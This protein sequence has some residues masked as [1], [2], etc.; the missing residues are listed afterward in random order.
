MGFGW[1]QMGAVAAGIL[2]L[3]GLF[4]ACS[5][6]VDSVQAAG[7]KHV[8]LVTI[9]GLRGDALGAFESWYTRPVSVQ[10]PGDENAKPEA[11]VRV[12]VTPNLDRLAEAS[13][14]YGYALATSSWCAPSVASIMASQ[15]PSYLGFTS[16]ER[17]FEG[18]HVTLAEVL[19]GAGWKTQAFV[20]HPFLRTRYN[21]DQGF[22]EYAV[23]EGETSGER[24][25]KTM[26]QALDAIG[27]LGEHSTLLWVQLGGLGPPFDVEEGGQPLTRAE[28]LR[29]R[30]QWQNEDLSIL[31][32]RYNAGVQRVD[33]QV[34]QLLQA[35][36]EAG[37]D[38]DTVVVCVASNGCELLER[39]HIG[40]GT[41]LADSLVRV[42]CMISVAGVKPGVIE[43]PVSLID[44]APSVLRLVGLRAPRTWQGVSV[45][46]REPV[47]DR[48]LFSE[49]SRARELRAALHSDHKLILDPERGTHQLYDVF[50][51][52]Y[53][54]RDLAI[55]QGALGYDLLEALKAF[56]K[57]IQVE[58]TEH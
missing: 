9:E 3:A 30:D 51:D 28:W 29:Y 4:A 6:S 21:L 19:R 56:E 54:E 48:F 32:E 10:I 17:S 5:P 11:P 38:G 44:L 52:P 22:E 46:P 47:P 24:T 12:A 25:A 42:P 27:D 53:E 40:D 41:S 45:L 7:R 49:L 23:A 2:G 37:A 15:Y 55:Q 13:F 35:L 14:T 34:G 43:D 16:L 8:L 39:G 58:A 18:R 1:K 31:R 57:G 33:E 26:S 20:Q 36:V 50:A